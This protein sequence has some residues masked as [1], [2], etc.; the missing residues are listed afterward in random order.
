MISDFRQTTILE[1]LQALGSVSVADLVREFNVSEMTIR[2]DLAILENRGLLRRVHGGATSQRGRSYEPPFISR[3]GENLDAKRRIGA[4][5]AALVQNGDS[6]TLD[7]GTTTLEI[8]R[9]LHAKQDLTVITPSLRIA[10]ELCDHP[11]IRLILTGGILRSSE[12]SMVGHLAER[13]FDDFFVDKLFLGAGAVDV[14]AGVS[15]FNIEDTLVKRAM[16][17]SAKKVFLAADSSKFHQVALT[18]IVPLANVH[19]II[20]DTDLD[21]HLVTQIRKE[22]IE[23]IL[24]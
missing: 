24:A 3:A 13:I 17:R 20:S 4:A 2:R 22:G 15:E 8:A 7:V 1:K 6:I 16:V 5:A 21:P 10:N 23:V 9:S 18:S 11:G 19:T 14:K 12:Y